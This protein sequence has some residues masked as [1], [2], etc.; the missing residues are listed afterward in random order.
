[1]QRPRNRMGPQ[2]H[3]FGFARSVSLREVH[4]SLRKICSKCSQL[5]KNRARSNSHSRK[6]IFFTENAVSPCKIRIYGICMF[7]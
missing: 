3:I 5:D 4:R 2:E 6:H 7:S 1:M